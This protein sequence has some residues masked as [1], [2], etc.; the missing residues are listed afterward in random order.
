MLS[1]EIPQDNQH[2]KPPSHAEFFRM[3]PFWQEQ[4]MRNLLPQELLKV[5]NDEMIRIGPFDFF[6]CSVLTF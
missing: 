1:L 3:T 4:D 2:P 6:C 5:G